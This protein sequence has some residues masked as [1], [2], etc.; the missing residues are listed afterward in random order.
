MQTRRYAKRQLTWF[1]RYGRIKFF[2][3]DD[4]DDPG[5]LISG[6]TDYIRETL[7]EIR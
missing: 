5:D 7:N 1:R 2:Y 6:V 3:L 4:Y